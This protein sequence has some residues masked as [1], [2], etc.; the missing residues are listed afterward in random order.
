M[1]GG[2]RE[3]RGGGGGGARVS[4]VK[5]VNC[6]LV[7]Q[8]FQV[9]G[10]VFHGCPRHHRIFST[11]SSEQICN[12]FFCVNLRDVTVSRKMSLRFHG[13]GRT[14][15]RSSEGGGGLDLC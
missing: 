7:H 11:C 1:R 9:T 8:Q 10:T 6:S 12:F 5:T 3:V 2:S 14:D 15:G 13:A 4:Q